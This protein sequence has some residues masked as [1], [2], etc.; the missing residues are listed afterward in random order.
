MYSEDSNTI[1]VNEF[2]ISHGIRRIDLAVV[3]GVMR[4]YEIKSE[5]DKLDRLPSQSASFSSVFD[6]LTLVVSTNH[7]T[8]AVE[9]L[10]QWWGITEALWD[11]DRIILMERREAQ[12]NPATD[13]RLLVALLWREEALQALSVRGLDKGLRTAP[14]TRM[15]QVL[16]DAVPKAEL[17][18]IVRTSICARKGHAT[19]SQWA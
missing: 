18:A 16:L 13:P 2:G 8:K 17:Q 11:Q 3:N 4:G 10:P 19:F 9:L 14:R 6:F 15:W 7:L 1:I 12:F 5:K